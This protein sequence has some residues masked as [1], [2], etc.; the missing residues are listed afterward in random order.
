MALLVVDDLSIAFGGLQALH[1]VS[2]TVESGEILGLLGPNGSGK[3][4][5]FNV[6][7]GIY[8]ADSGSVRFED[9]TI[10]GMRPPD[11]SK[12][13][14]ARTFQNLQLFNSMTVYDNV[15]TAVEQRS[16]RSVAAQ[17]FV[18]GRGRSSHANRSRVL[19]LLEFVGLDDQRDQLADNLAFGHQRL[20]EMARALATQPRL[21]LLDEP[22][23]GMNFGEM[24]ALGVLLEHIRDHFNITIVLVAHTM[25]LVMRTCGRLVVLHNGEKIAEGQPADVRNDPLVIDAYLGE[26]PED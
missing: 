22:S 21:L 25:R 26:V 15:L 18:P 8:R 19:E 13:G 6:V 17:V 24:D 20:L 7:S 4:T 3:T 16:L 10:S 2:M 11:I 5:L 12:C 1:S 9:R 14:I 23:A